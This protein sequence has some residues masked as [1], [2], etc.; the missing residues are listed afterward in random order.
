MAAGAWVRPGSSAHAILGPLQFV[1]A[2]ATLHRALRQM[3]ASF[4]AMRRPQL[5][6]T[7]RIRS[8]ELRWRRG[9][10]QGPQGSAGNAAPFQNALRLRRHDDGWRMIDW[11]RPC[12]GHR[13]PAK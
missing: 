13:S 6:L 9:N 7:L 3:L 5:T 11:V 1:C 2:T 12:R 8:P 4:Y 10:R